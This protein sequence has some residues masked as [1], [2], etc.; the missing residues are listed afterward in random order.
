[1][2]S[3]YTYKDLIWVDLES[4]S[5]S[6][7]SHTIEQYAIPPKLSNQNENNNELKVSSYADH[8]QIKLS[9]PEVTENSLL[10]FQDIELLVNNS[11]IITIHSEPIKS[12]N[13]FSKKFE[14]NAILENHQELGNINNLSFNIINLLYSENRDKLKNIEDLIKSIEGNIQN[15]PGNKIGLK[16]SNINNV[17]DIFHQNFYK[18]KEIINSL[19]LLYKNNLND[20]NN[21]YGSR[22]LHEYVLIKSQIESHREKVNTLQIINN[23]L[24]IKKN[25]KTI[26]IMFAIII[27]LAIISVY[28]I[29]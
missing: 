5:K 9:F 17:L 3:K 11:Y 2:I 14:I 4:P 24:I 19:D 22:L 23:Q 27:V 8:T 1:M 12:L 7:I 18:H 10:N 25:R 6:E 13:D 26:K 15:K 16:I 28:S 21:D 20:F 29:I